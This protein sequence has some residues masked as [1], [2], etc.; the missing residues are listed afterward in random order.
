MLPG[1]WHALLV[2]VIMGVKTRRDE[3]TWRLQ[4]LA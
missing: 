2:T 1:S 3:T 4:C